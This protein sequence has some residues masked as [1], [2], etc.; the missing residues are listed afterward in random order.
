M[1][2]RNLP[3]SLPTAGKLVRQSPSP[4]KVYETKVCHRWEC[5]RQSL[6][7]LGVCETNSVATRSVWDKI[8]H[9][10]ECVRQ[11]LSLLR[12][13]ESKTVTAESVW[14][15]DCHCWE[16]VRQ[17]LSLLRVC[18]TNSVTTGSVWV[19]DCHCWEC[20][21]QRLLLLRMYESKAVTAESVW[22]KRPSSKEEHTQKWQKINL[23]SCFVE[24]FLGFFLHSQFAVCGEVLGAKKTLNELQTK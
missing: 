24:M 8:C 19:K 21:N 10:W 1:Y 5:V 3:C 22:D 13:C 9:C 15:K 6:T 17:S 12:V 7:L 23:I 11:R 16:C 18:E 14:V 20:V 2:D 4:P